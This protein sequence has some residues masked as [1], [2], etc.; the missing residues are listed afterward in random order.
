MFTNSQGTFFLDTQYTTG[1]ELELGELINYTLFFSKNGILE[2]KFWGLA[3][4]KLLIY[5]YIYI[6]I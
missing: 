1:W 3:T 6:F 5:I 2:Y 4:S